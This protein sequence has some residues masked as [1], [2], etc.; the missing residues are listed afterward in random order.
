MQEREY[1]VTLYK[2]EDLDSFYDDI[3]TPGGNIFI[4]DRAVPVKNRRPVSR[5]THYRLTNEEAAQIRQDPRVKAVELS[6]EEAGLKI[7]PSWTQSSTFWNKSNSVSSLHKNWGLLRVVEGQ[8]RPSWGFNSINNTSGEINVTASGKYV[9]I[10]IVD[11]HLNP[12]HPEFAVNTDGTGGSRVSQYNWF[13]LNPIVIFDSPDSYV[14]TPY[15]DPTYPDNNED[16]ISDRT[17]D[18]DHG[19]HVAGITAGNTQ[20]WAR[21]AT[22]YNISPYTSAPSPTPYFSDYIKVWHQNKEINPLTGNKNPTITNHSYGIYAEVDITEIT[23]ISYRGT[24]ITGPFTSLQLLNYG[25]FNSGG[26]AYINQRNTEIEE[27]LIDLMAAGVIVVGSAGNVYSKIAN[28]TELVSDDYNNYFVVGS[29]EYYYLRGTIT[30]VSNAICVG[31]IGSFIDDSKFTTSNCGPR[32]DVYAPGRHIMSSINSN[33]GIYSNDVRNT[34]YYITKRSGTSMASPQVA[35]I[36]AC[37]AE[38]WPRLNQT[39][40]LTYIHD[41]S[42]LNQIT[43]GTGG[44]TDYT[45]LQGS[46]NRFLYFYKERPDTGQVGPKNNQGLR[47]ATGQAW[48]RPKIYRYGR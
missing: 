16:G 14:Y 9:D 24:I 30:A 33:I 18:N 6:L 17:T 27:D 43:A 3:E 2:H 38:T 7:K 37:L 48:P 4:P 25:I 39:Q 11:G 41:R 26:I 35:G 12:D 32:I 42:K 29:T 28:E 47:P 1:V 20:G 10:V 45:D 21:D 13:E 46:A 19:S 22:I 31:A 23:S 8:Q 40:A 36:L 5:N 15:V 44:P 34:S